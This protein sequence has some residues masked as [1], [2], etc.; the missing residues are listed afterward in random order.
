MSLS[1]KQR[2][3]IKL[4]AMWCGIATATITTS[5]WITSGVIAGLDAR[6]PTIEQSSKW[7]QDAAMQA[8]GYADGIKGQIT[9][10]L[11]ASDHRLDRIEKNQDEMLL[12]TRYLYHTMHGEI[13][14]G[15]R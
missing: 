12:H 3:W 4:L 13:A 8:T 2:S 15:P 11:N 1:P 9:E 6:Y 10:R 7:A 14:N 5:K